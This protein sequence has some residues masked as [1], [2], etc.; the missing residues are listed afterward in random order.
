[1]PT[2]YTDQFFLFDPANPPARNTPVTFSRLTLVDQNNDRDVDRFDGDSV[3]GSDI[4]ASYPGDTVTIRVNNTNITYRGTTFYLANGQRV[5]TPTD[6]QILQNGTFR[7]STFVQT[8]GPLLVPAQLGPPCFTPGALI[9]TPDGE[10]PVEALRPGDLVTTRDRGAQ[11]VIWA[12]AETVPGTGDTAPVLIRA[13]AMGNRRDLLLSP[14]H[15]MLMRGWR[16]ELYAGL[17]EALVA[18]VHLVNGRTMLRAPCAAV[19]YV[20]FMLERHEIVFAEGA[21]TESLDPAGDAA[22]ADREILRLVPERA[23][24]APRVRPALRGWEGRALA[25]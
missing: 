17:S 14:Q 22:L 13:G 8:Q 10:R 12:G 4:T 3:N 16:A 2:T 6:G 11:P 15:R 7:S 18:A 24:G 9:L 19:T 25:L 21:E 23:G 1:L 20:H 5:F